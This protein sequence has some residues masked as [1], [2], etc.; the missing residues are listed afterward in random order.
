MV[1]AAA[2]RRAASLLLE[3][4]NT[5]NR[6]VCQVLSLREATYYYKPKDR[7]DGPVEKRMKELAERFRRYGYPRLH[8]LLNREGLVVN[9]KRT[10]RIYRRLGLQIGK[11]KRKKMPRVVRVPLPKASKPGEVWSMDFVFDALDCGRR[12]KFMPVVDDFTKQCETL[13]VDRSISGHDIVRHF[14]SLGKKPKRIRCDNGPEF[15]SKALLQ[16]AHE[17]D[18]HIEFIQPGKPQQN[19]YIESFNGKFRDEF[20]NENLFFTVEDAREKVQDWLEEYHSIRPHRSLGMTPN[21]FA[22]RF[23]G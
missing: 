9:E 11:R 3:K 18:V 10:R 16:W 15:Q 23:V 14:E 20:L 7:G 13:H 2:K 4:F 6:R 5:S 21:E 8:F 19:A 22:E 17:N 12:L 1:G